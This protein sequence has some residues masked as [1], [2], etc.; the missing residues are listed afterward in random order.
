MFMNSRLTDGAHKEAGALRRN[1]RRPNR[2]NL[3]ANNNRRDDDGVHLEGCSTTNDF[4]L[5]DD[6]D[7]ENQAMCKNG[8]KP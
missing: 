4:D 7:E 1:P 6:D 2:P 5:A 8:S 3:P